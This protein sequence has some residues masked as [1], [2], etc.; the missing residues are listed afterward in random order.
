MITPLMSR[1]SVRYWWEDA[2]WGNSVPSYH[3]LHCMFM[4]KSVAQSCLTL[5]DPMNCNPPGFSVHGILQARILESVAIPF[6]RGSLWPRDWAWVSC[7]AGRFFTVWATEKSQVYTEPL[8]E[9]PQSYSKFPLAIYFAYGNVSFHVTLSIHFT[10]SSP[11]PIVHMSIL[12]VCPVNEFFTTIFLDSY[13]CVRI[14]Y[15]SFSFWLTSHNR[16]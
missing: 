10:L 8:F 7:I 9:F 15:L 1:G 14:W 2:I 12:Y 3:G 16:F 13:I 4:W 11:L 5:C 6:S